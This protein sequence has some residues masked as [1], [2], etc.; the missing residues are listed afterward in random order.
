[1]GGGPGGSN[2][3][4]WPVFWQRRSRRLFPHGSSRLP[5]GRVS[6]ST[7]WQVRGT[8]KE[9]YLVLCRCNG[10]ANF[11]QVIL[12]NFRPPKFRLETVKGVRSEFSSLSQKGVGWPAYAMSRVKIVHFIA[13]CLVNI[14]W[15]W[16]TQFCTPP[17]PTPQHAKNK[18][19]NLDRKKSSN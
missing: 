3:S 12:H 6:C 4:L 16:H 2:S 14:L 13:Y 5:Y 17:Q 8:Y 9:S 10:H 19:T 15:H 1:M 7:V 18:N 11:C